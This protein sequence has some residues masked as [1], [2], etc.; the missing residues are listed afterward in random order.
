MDRAGPGGGLTLRTRL[1]DPPRLLEYDWIEHDAPGGAIRNSVVRF[2]LAAK[3]DGVHLMLTHRPLPT[4]SYTTIGA[5]G[6]AHLDTLVAQAGGQDGPDAN[7]R[8]AVIGPR[9]GALASFPSGRRRALRT[10]R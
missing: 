10:R 3:G 8:Y 9:Y 4:E 2:E 1:F 5:G 6:Y 7:A